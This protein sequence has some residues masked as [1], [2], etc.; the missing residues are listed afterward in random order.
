MANTSQFPP[1]V[2]ETSDIIAIMAE[3]GMSPLRGTF[4]QLPDLPIPDTPVST[5]TR[6]PLFME[7]G[8]PKKKKRRLGTRDDPI[9]IN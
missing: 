8:A 2:T 5:P 6:R 7:P 3:L 9:V 1:P 4:V